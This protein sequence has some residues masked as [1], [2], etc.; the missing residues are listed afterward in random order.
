MKKYQIIIR[1][2]GTETVLKRL[3]V[4]AYDRDAAELKARGQ[5]RQLGYGQRIRCGVKEVGQ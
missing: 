3:C 4:Q 5:M 1:E 2:A